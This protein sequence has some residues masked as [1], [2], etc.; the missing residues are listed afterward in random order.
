MSTFLN[1]SLAAVAAVLIALTS[2]S[3]IVTV[4]DHSDA[5]T[6]APLLA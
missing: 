2:L 3:A 6:A 5:V 1:N 4:P